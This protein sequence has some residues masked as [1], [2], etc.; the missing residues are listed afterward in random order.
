MAVCMGGM[1]WLLSS[2]ARQARLAGPVVWMQ[3]C[4]TA[5]TPLCAVSA[6]TVV[7]AD[8]DSQTYTALL[9][10]SCKSLQIRAQV[11]HSRHLLGAEQISSNLN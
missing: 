1:Q 5:L 9:Q 8:Q 4:A 3:A 6:G 7:D 2:F 10:G 11:Q